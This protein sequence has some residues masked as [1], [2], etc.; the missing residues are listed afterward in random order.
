MVILTKVRNFAAFCAIAGVTIFAIVL[1]AGTAQ[2]VAADDSIMTVSCGECSGDA[3]KDKG[4]CDKDKGCCGKDKPKDKD[5][6]KEGDKPDG[7]AHEDGDKGGDAHEDK[8]K[9]EHKE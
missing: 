3:S 2:K 8:D 4:S 9:D 1:F 6:H 7:P 5:L